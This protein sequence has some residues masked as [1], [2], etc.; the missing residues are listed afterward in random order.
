MIVVALVLVVLL[1]VL[2]PQM[3]R[4]KHSAVCINNLK[5]V[6]LA[7]LLYRDDHQLAF[8]PGEVSTN[9]GGTLEYLKRGALSEYFKR[10]TNE[11]LGAKALVCPS[12][13]RKAAR[14]FKTLGDSNLSYFVNADIGHLGGGLQPFNRVV[15][16]LGDRNVTNGTGPLART[17]S[18][19][20]SNQLGWNKEMHNKGRRGSQPLLGNV[21]MI[22]GSVRTLT[23]TGLQQAFNYEGSSRLVLP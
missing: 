4:T 16:A 17:I 14:S 13:H 3:V 7:H 10:L 1:A 6:S 22:D 11:F 19:T 23:S 9:E 21:A 20:Q 2:L 5:Q 8:Y 15:I 18:V 12:D